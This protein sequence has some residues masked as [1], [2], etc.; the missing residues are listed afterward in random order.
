MSYDTKAKS[1]YNIIQ[2]IL[3]SAFVVVHITVTPNGHLYLSATGNPSVSRGP[4]QPLIGQTMYNNA[5]LLGDYQKIP[6][7][8]DY[9]SITVPQ[10]VTTL[11]Q[12]LRPPPPPPPHLQSNVTPICVDGTLG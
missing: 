4:T 6:T 2:L 8:E 3:C 11:I 12:Q 7:E 10:H 9:H 5:R 1:H